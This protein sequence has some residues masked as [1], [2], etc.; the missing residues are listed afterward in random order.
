MNS[1]CFICGS[2]EY[3]TQMIDY[4]NGITS[5]DICWP[6]QNEIESGVGMTVYKKC[7]IEIAHKLEGHV[8]CGAVHGHSVDIVVGIKGYLDLKTG[9]VMDFKSIKQIIQKEIINKFDHTLL[10]DILPIPTAEYLAY[11]IFKQLKFRNFNVALIRVHET[12]DNYVEY[13]GDNYNNGR[14][15][16]GDHKC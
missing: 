6:C 14:D 9:M 12:K 7:T 13:D 5:L 4:G 15:F 1:E 10:N 16:L 11:Y 8:T 2:D 3:H